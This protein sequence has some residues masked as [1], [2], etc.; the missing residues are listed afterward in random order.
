M[1]CKTVITFSFVRKRQNDKKIKNTEHL[2]SVIGQKWTFDLN[3][4][5]SFEWSLKMCFCIAQSTKCRNKVCELAFSLCE[6]L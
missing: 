6:M 4:V 3:P 5:K 2:L 1:F